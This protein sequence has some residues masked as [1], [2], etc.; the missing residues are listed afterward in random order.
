VDWWEVITLT[1]GDEACLRVWEGRS[2][3]EA[4]EAA[5]AAQAD[6]KT[7]RIYIECNSKIVW[8]NGSLVAP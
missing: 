1:Q 7:L 3:K 6:P 5:Q 4:M 2:P 8:A